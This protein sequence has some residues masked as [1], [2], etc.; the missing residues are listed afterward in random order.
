M[1]FAR[2]CVSL[3][4]LCCATVIGL[5]ISAGNLRAEPA[6]TK[7][8]EIQSDDDDEVIILEGSRADAYRL[9]FSDGT[10]VEMQ[11]HSL[12]IRHDLSGPD[13]RRAYLFVLPPQNKYNIGLAVQ[14]LCRKRKCELPH[15]YLWSGIPVS[16]ALLTENS[17]LSLPQPH[18]NMDLLT[19][20][21]QIMISLDERR[22]QD[23]V[24]SINLDHIG[25]QSQ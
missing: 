16:V 17:F 24:F 13:A 2:K 15:V 14:G 4:L 12:V 23:H 21:E 19:R 5:L 6:Q 22:Q 10:E 18:T 7:G 20:S 8:E 1:S 11:L 3:C 9:R 25:T